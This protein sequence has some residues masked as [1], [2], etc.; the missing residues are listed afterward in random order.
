M[1]EKKYI[2]NKGEKSKYSDF[3]IVADIGATNSR[4]GVFGKNIQK[5]QDIELILH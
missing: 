4:F 3:C 1:I 5:N 2:E